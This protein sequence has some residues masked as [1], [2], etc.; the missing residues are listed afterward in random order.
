[1]KIY[2]DLLDIVTRQQMVVI[3]ISNLCDRVHDYKFSRD[4]PFFSTRDLAEFF[5]SRTYDEDG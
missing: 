4:C 3:H 1:M 2:V 5:L